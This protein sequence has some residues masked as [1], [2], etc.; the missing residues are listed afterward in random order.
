MKNK[1]E[2]DN[3]SEYEDGS[4]EQELQFINNTFFAC[5]KFIPESLIISLLIVFGKIKYSF[6]DFDPKR[7]GFKLDENR[8][9]SSNYDVIYQNKFYPNIY[10]GYSTIN[11]YYSLWEYG[12]KAHS[13]MPFELGFFQEIEIPDLIFAVKLI[14]QFLKREVFDA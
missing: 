8:L 14:R 11:D 4:K 5:Q 1:F 7:L 10:L 13:V 3:L 2:I 9:L 6:S 12:N